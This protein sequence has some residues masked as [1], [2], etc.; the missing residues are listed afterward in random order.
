MSN[1]TAAGVFIVVSLIVIVAA[2]L[3]VRATCGDRAG[4]STKG[5]INPKELNVDRRLQ[6]A[7]FKRAHEGRSPV[8]AGAEATACCPADDRGRTEPKRT[9]SFIQFDWE[10]PVWASMSRALLQAT[11]PTR[12]AHLRSLS[13][14]SSMPGRGDASVLSAIARPLLCVTT[15][16]S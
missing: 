1:A 2:V 9:T 11:I 14:I 13:S 8:Q 12:L 4:G 15:G 6:R 16:P 3:I 5:I 10:W 7:T